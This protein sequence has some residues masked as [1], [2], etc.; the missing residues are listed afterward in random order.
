MVTPACESWIA[1]LVSKRL[2]KD[3]V[4]PPTDGLLPQLMIAD[5]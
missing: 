3:M 5:H 4:T 1:H 2:T